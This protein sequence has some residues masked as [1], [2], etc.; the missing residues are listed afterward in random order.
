MSKLA[1]CGLDCG[2]CGAYTATQ[3]GEMEAKKKLAEEWS[4]AYGADIKAEDIHCDG[5][6]AGTGRVIGHWHECEIRKCAQEN[7]KVSSCGVCKDFPCESVNGL[8]NLVPE[9]KA[10]LEKIHNEK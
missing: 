8:M 10:N 9:A 5:C 1:Y 6:C 7:E 3:S 4:K 2:A